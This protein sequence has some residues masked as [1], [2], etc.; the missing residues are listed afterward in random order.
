MLKIAG[1]Q[2][3]L[4]LAV[5]LRLL[6]MPF[7]FHSDIKT[8]HFQVSFLR[9]GVTNIYS[10]LD[11]HK[12]SLPIKEGFAYYPLAYFFLGGYQVMASPL[13]GD[14]FNHWLSDASSSANEQNE[15]FRY[16]FILK[17][18]YL[19]L[20][21]LIAFVL[22]TFFIEEKQKKRVLTLWLLNPFSIVLI[23]AYAGFDII[24]VFLVL[25]SLMLAAKEKLFWAALLLGLGA[26]FKAYPLLFVP[27]LFLI[28][29][30]KG[31][32]IQVLLA[33]LVPFLL[34]I[35][36]FLNTANFRESVLTS[37]QMTRLTL[38]GLN[39][40]FGESLMVSVMALAGFFFWRG[41]E[42]RIIK[43]DLWRY[44][45]V[46]LLLIFSFMHFHIQWLLWLL[47][48]AVISFVSL[49]QLSSIVGVLFALAF[50]IP[51][52]YD[53]KAMTVGLLSSISP[54]YNLLPTP[55]TIIQKI[56]DPY[57][58]QSILHSI[59][60]GGSLVLVW[61]IFKKGETHE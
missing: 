4:I 35:G 12:T 32:K 21:I 17:L 31:Q 39:L 33:S 60:A 58:A 25:L 8:Y 29:K 61:Q 41:L 38:V 36:P 22:T 59:F 47:P 53:D 48:L 43:K 56:Y 44:Y 20:D 28:G 7:Y 34:I 57:I 55:F 30:D 27:L 19:I 46:L 11:S 26:A 45:F 40:G 24:P 49:R 52:F 10:Y 9:E 23:Y 54:L 13:L 1:W 5:F 6:I 37:G 51:V 14:N 50:L 3:I 42:V 16:L 15:V 18:P 2:K